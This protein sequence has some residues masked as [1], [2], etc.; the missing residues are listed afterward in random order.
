[1]RPPSIEM[2]EQ[3]LAVVE[4]EEQHFAP[5]LH[6]PHGPADELAL[7]GF[8]RDIDGLGSSDD[9]VRYW[10]AGDAFRQQPAVMFHFRIFRHA[11]TSFLSALSLLFQPACQP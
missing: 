10:L 5:P 4:V 3:P 11:K 1:M 6:E 7:K 2:Q 8:H 9:Y